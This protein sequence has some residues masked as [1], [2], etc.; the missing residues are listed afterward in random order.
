MSAPYVVLT[1]CLNC[2]ISSSL[3]V[4]VQ[5]ATTRVPS[6]ATS[7]LISSSVMSLLMI[8]T[9]LGPPAALGLADVAPVLADALAA[10]ADALAALALGDAALAL[11]AVLAAVLALAAPLAPGLDEQ[12]PRSSTAVAATAR[13]RVAPLVCRFACI[14]ASSSMRCRPTRHRLPRSLRPPT[15]RA[16]RRADRGPVRSGPR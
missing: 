2:L 14:G 5:F 13:T 8:A 12:A 16:P 1:Y 11:A 15:P 10:L 4:Y 7:A 6:L 9:C 3:A